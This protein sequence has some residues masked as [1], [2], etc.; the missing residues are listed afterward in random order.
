MLSDDD[1]KWFAKE[2]SAA[3][4]RRLTSPLLEWEQRITGRLDKFEVQLAAEFQKWSLPATDDTHV[5]AAARR[6]M[7]LE[8]KA[9]HDERRHTGIGGSR[10]SSPRSFCSRLARHPRKKPASQ[11]C[12][13]ES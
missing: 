12:R 8:L 7:G 11:F 9:L 6:A 4:T 1:K 3:G 5:E 2:T 13:L 10:P